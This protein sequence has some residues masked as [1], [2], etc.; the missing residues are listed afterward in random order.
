[1]NIV[2]KISPFFVDKRGAMFSLLEENTKIRSVLLISCKKGAVRANHYHKHDTHY[3]YVL[4]GVMEYTYKDLT[5]R[6]EKKK[7][8]IVREGYLVTTQPMVAHAMY[9]PE[10]SLFLT[11]TT[12]RRDPIAYE[13]DTVRTKLLQP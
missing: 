11:L 1:M 10:D 7:T 6:K 9:F 2:K 12:E 5:A 8:M 13:R 3:C 4:K